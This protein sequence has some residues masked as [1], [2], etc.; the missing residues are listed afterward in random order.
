LLFAFCFLV[1]YGM[2]ERGA[3]YIAVCFFI[4]PALHRRI[5]VF[6]FA[7]ACSFGNV[8]IML[9]MVFFSSMGR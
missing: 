1:W 5:I 9:L 7:F 2:D 8:Q 4:G 3:L 6:F